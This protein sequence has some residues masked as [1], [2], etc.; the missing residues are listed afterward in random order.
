M[1]IPHLYVIVVQLNKLGLFGS[2]KGI[3]SHLAESLCFLIHGNALN[4]QFIDIG[5]C[6]GNKFFNC[7]I[8][9]QGRSEGKIQP[10]SLC[11]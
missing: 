10:G 5:L 9:F 11:F 7:C 8:L 4:S 1:F 2:G 3:E 6:F